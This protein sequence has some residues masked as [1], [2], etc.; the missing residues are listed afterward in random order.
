MKNIAITEDRATIAT[1][2]EQLRPD[3]QALW[4]KMDVAQMLVHCREGLKLATGELK[5]KRLWLG[6][7]LGPLIK[8]IYYNE[9]PFTKNVQTVKE[10]KITST[11]AFEAAK[12]ELLDAL[13]D[14]NNKKALYGERASHPFL[15]YLTPEQWGKG[16]YK[17]LDHH[18][19]QFGV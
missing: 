9:K 2:I 5:L 14:Y 17:H 18:L 15:G 13:E 3:S 7:L 12:Q 10:I 8:S 11:V 16:M 4:G 6:Y 1:R 19:R